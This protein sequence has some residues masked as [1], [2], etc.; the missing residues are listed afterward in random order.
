M[1]NTNYEE[2]DFIKWYR[3]EASEKDKALIK[4]IIEND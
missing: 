2:L 3:S 4:T 1:N